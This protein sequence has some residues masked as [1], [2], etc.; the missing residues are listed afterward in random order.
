MSPKSSPSLRAVPKTQ[1]EGEEEEEEKEE[2]EEDKRPGIPQACSLPHE[3]FLLRGLPSLSCLCFLLCAESMTQDS[4][5][6]YLS[7]AGPSPRGYLPV[8]VDDLVEGAGGGT[9]QTDPG[10]YPALSFSEPADPRT[11]T[12]RS[13]SP[14]SFPQGKCQGHLQP[15]PDVGLVFE[16]AGR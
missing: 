15:H 12:P 7:L 16:E 9:A 3:S 2:E 4:A 8:L 11:G 10:L 6:E 14:G 13:R 5:P 1:L